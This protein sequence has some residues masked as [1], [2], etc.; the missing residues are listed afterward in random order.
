MNNNIL[1]SVVVP[2]YGT[3]KY[4]ERCARSLFEQTYDNIEYIFVDD[5][6]PDRSIDILK[7]EMRHYPQRERNVK[8]EKNVSNFGL[9]EVRN[10]GVSHCQGQFLMHVDSDDW[11]DTDVIER[12]VSKQSETDADI[13]VFDR[14]LYKNDGIK[15]VSSPEVSTSKD[16]T[17]QMLRRERDI[18]IWGM[19]IRTSLYKDHDITCRRGINMS[20]DYQTSPRLAYYAKSVA[21]VHDTFYNYE[22]RNMKSISATFTSKNVQQELVTLDVLEEF[23]SKKENEMLQAYEYGRCKMLCYYR[24]NA[25]YYDVHDIY[26][27]VSNRLRVL[28]SDI[29][30]QMPMPY[31]IG[32]KIS[33]ESIL[34]VYVG[35]LK[36]LKK[37][38]R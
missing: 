5:C 31:R 12:C 30:N 16:F 2:V 15:L 20:E 6:T 37:K 1:V 32:L 26:D 24:H 17:T 36:Q 25:A 11:L 38:L 14:K 23:F 8:I 28:S 35:I 34:K 27:E 7:E 19:L 9:A 3:E 22:C 10:V 21:F 18:S 33:S 13:I 4:I 29:K